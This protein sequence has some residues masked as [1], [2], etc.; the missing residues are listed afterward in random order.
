[1]VS[2][3]KVL[4]KFNLLEEYLRIVKQISQAPE[5]EFLKDKILIGSDKYYIQISIECCIDVAT[6]IISSE[7]FRSPT[8]YADSFR[9]L[10]ENG[11]FDKELTSRLVQM[12]KFRNRLV[13]LYGEIQDDFVY[14]AITIDLKDIIRFQE[15]IKS[16]FP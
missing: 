13:H 15:R 9:V 3:Q 12:A 11:I 14:R 2:P 4:K 7:G 10:M 1:M 16:H 5:E 6:H 8:E